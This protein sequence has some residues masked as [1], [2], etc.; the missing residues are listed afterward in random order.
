MPD[1]LLLSAVAQFHLNDMAAAAQNDLDY[2]ASVPKT[3]ARSTS[4][5]TSPEWPACSSRIVSA[6]PV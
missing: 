2:E 3:E 1:A 5:Y 4:R 6:L